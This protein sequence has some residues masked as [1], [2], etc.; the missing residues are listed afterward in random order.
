MAVHPNP[1]EIRGPATNDRIV[2]LKRIVAAGVQSDRSLYRADGLKRAGGRKAHGRS[3]TAVHAQK[4]VAHRISVGVP[5]RHDLSARCVSS[6]MIELEG[7]RVVAHV[8]YLL[9][10]RACRGA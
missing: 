3:C 6:N 5:D 8:T 2:E 10:T 1:I 9:S 4:G 7:T